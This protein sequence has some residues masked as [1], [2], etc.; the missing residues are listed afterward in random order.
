MIFSAW[1]V[2]GWDWQAQSYRVLSQDEILARAAAQIPLQ[3]QATPTASQ[4]TALMNYRPPVYV[5]DGWRD[6]YATGD[7]LH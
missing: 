7:S 2:S 1:G 6:W 4:L 5:P 3:Q